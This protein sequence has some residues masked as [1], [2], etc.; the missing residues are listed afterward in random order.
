MMVQYPGSRNP[1]LNYGGFSE[2]LSGQ[3]FHWLKHSLFHIYAFAYKLALM[4][5]EQLFSALSDTTR[6]RA[7]MLIQSEGE[8]CVCEL[9]FALEVSQPKISR[10]LA[11]LRDTGILKPRR[12]G[13]WMHYRIDPDLPAWAVSSIQQIL[14]QLGDLDRFAADRARLKNM[15]NRPGEK[16]CA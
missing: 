14:Q 10:H 6:L 3:I 2:P 12:K 13:T 16:N 15:T 4:E 5:P 8:V 9:T 7:L 1:L 11:L